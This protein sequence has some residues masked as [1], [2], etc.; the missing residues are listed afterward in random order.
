M[1]SPQQALQ[2]LER[3]IRGR[4]APTK[5]CFIRCVGELL[6]WVED[7]DIDDSQPGTLKIEVLHSYP[8][9]IDIGPWVVPVLER[10]LA[11]GVAYTISY[12]IVPP[13]SGELR[14]SRCKPAR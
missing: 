4:E 1:T 6:Q 5:L 12:R 9:G 14:A 2:I 10:H 11:M 13:G 3:M 8:E 7:V